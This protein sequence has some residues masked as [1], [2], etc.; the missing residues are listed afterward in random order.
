MGQ[1]TRDRSGTAIRTG[2]LDALRRGKFKVDNDDAPIPTPD[3]YVEDR[4]VFSGQVGDSR[5]VWQVRLSSTTWEVIG[6]PERV[7][8]GT[9]LEVQPSMV[10]GSEGPAGPRA[11]LVY[12]G[13]TST[14]NIWSLPTDANQ[15][16]VAGD[17]RLS[18]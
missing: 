18:G 7:T 11:R 10:A 9:S 16:K 1:P 15:G 17:P 6:E 14:L 3:Y 5:N 8:S 13:L 12:A 4:V 2:A